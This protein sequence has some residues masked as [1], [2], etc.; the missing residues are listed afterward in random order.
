V[1]LPDAL[2]FFESGLELHLECAVVAALLLE[3]TQLEDSYRV[4]LRVVSY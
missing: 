4:S 1:A 2:Q 3:L